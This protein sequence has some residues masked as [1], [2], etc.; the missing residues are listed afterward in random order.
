MEAYV[1]IGNPQTRKS[2]LIRCLTGCY[3]R[4]VRDIALQR[5]DAIRVY[6]RISALQESRTQAADFIAEVQRSRCRQV[7]FSLWPEA[8]TQDTQRWPDA[9]SY[10][11]ALKTAGWTFRKTAVLGA[12][13]LKLD[14][15]G[16]VAQFPNVLTQPIN[17][18]AQLIRNH[19]GWK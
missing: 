12:Y 2:S 15:A 19:F 17:A 11:Q 10:L 9:A 16:E 5:G 3:S 7:L 18:S 4:G 6:A 8:N 13:P 14:Q 1:L